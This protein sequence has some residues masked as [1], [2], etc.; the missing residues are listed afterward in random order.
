MNKPEQELKLLFELQKRNKHI[1]PDVFEKAAKILKIWSTLPQTKLSSA[2]VKIDMA[3]SIGVI[4]KQ[5]S[6]KGVAE[7]RVTVGEENSIRVSTD[8]VTSEALVAITG[9]HLA[10]SPEDTKKAIEAT[11]KH[12][13]ETQKIENKNGV[14]FGP[15]SPKEQGPLLF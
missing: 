9:I 5:N 6:K 12:S 11:E 14:D 7:V 15:I 1:R 2:L 10:I 4:L 13:K 8:S 3:G